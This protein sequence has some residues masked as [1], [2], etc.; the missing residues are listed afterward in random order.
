MRAMG[1]MGI[2]GVGLDWWSGRM[3][4]KNPWTL[5]RNRLEPLVLELHAA[6]PWRVEAPLTVEAWLRGLTWEDLWLADEASRSLCS[7]PPRLDQW[8]YGPQ[9]EDSPA[10]QKWQR[11][12]PATVVQV[13]HRMLFAVDLSRE[14]PATWRREFPLTGD[15]PADAR[16]V[17]I[18]GWRSN[19][20]RVWARECGHLYV[21][22]EDGGS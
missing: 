19:A 2:D 16:T 8:L 7:E 14:L 18:H 11:S 15:F 20:V 10:L 1:F 4:K 6:A 9:T 5:L 3:R 21:G 12:A 13:M 22:A 17:L